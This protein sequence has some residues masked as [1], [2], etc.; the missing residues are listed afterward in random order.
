MSKNQPENQPKDSNYQARMA[1]KKSHI[2][3]R[4]ESANIDKRLCILLTGNGKGKSSSAFGMVCRSLGY[5]FSIGVVAFIKGMQ[6]TGEALFFQTQPNI[7]YFAMQTGFTW[8]TQNK[9]AD[10]NAALATW[11]HA[12]KLLS[13]PSIDL[14]VLDEITY[15][16]N[17]KYLD[18]A[19]IIN[20]IN[21][22]P[23]HQ[24]LILTGRN[25]VQS[26][27]KVA[28]TISEIK[29][30]KHAFRDNIKAQKGI[31]L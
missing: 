4:I 19:M 27:H 1:R 25:A 24:H 22:R 13:D 11:Q 26:L 10:I 14:V 15:M 28:D 7:Q 29:D 6:E 2:D 12:Q 8:D 31:D 16:L 30:I 17:L 18:E 5:G 23:I 3:K 9:Q 21:N 20:A